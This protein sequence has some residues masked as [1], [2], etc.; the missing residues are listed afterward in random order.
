MK[1][2]K[3]VVSV[4]ILFSSLLFV[5][6]SAHAQNYS[7]SGRRPPRQLSERQLQMLDR[8][9][10]LIPAT[11]NRFEILALIMVESNLTSTAISH[12]GDYGLMQVNCRIWRERLRAEFQIQNC[13]EELLDVPTNLRIGIYILNRFKRYKQCRGSRVYACYN[14]GQSWR[15]RAERCEAS[16]GDDA[17]KRRCWRPAR[18]Q[19]SVRRHIRFLRRNYSERILGNTATT[20]SSQSR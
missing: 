12:T 8:V 6:Y 3:I 11:E 20:G 16:C 19:D 9:K 1:R 14:G 15:R 2:P 18:Y 4:L 10:V 7:G 13:E 5:L 17:C